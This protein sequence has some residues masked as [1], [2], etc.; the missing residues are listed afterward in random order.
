MEGIDTQDD[1]SLEF[2]KRIPGL[3][4]DDLQV[5]N[6]LN[7]ETESGSRYIFHVTS[8]DDKDG[9][10]IEFISGPKALEGAWGKLAD[11]RIEL[12]S[13]LDFEGGMTS[14]LVGIV[15][16]QEEPFKYPFV[17]L[18][19]N[20][21]LKEL[22]SDQLRV[23]DHIYF[24]AED[25]QTYVAEIMDV[26]E[27]MPLIKFVAGRNSLVGGEGYLKI[28]NLRIGMKFRN[29]LRSTMPIQNILVLPDMDEHMLDVLD[30]ECAI[31]ELE[32]DTEIKSFYISQMETLCT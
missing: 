14:T 6:Y 12:G 8:K 4:P 28:K 31:Q 25:G 17:K 2:N 13:I 7:L 22:D 23:G 20:K 5:D 32:Y 27:K 3:H 26:D 9:V 11:T 29:T 30:K 24:G 10:I 18:E 1:C 19:Y 21:S 15:V 16:T